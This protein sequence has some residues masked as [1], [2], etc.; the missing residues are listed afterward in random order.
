M[1]AW[2]YESLKT[3]TQEEYSESEEVFLLTVLAERLYAACWDCSTEL[4]AVEVSE[5]RASGSL[6]SE[7]FS[8][9]SVEVET[10]GWSTD[11]FFSSLSGVSVTVVVLTRVLDSSVSADV[12]SEHA[13]DSSEMCASDWC[14]SCAAAGDASGM[15]ILSLT[16]CVAE[17]EAGLNKSKSSFKSW[18]EE[19]L[20]LK[21]NRLDCRLQNFHSQKLIHQVIS[22]TFTLENFVLTR[23]VATS[24]Q[25]WRFL[26]SVT[27]AAKPRP[28]TCVIFNI[29]L[30]TRIL[31][32]KKKKKKRNWQC[33][34][35]WSCW[36]FAQKLGQMV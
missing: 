13:L 29:H 34:T 23:I 24:F 4:E 33:F 19:L 25:A 16:A 35:A 6:R 27:E 31:E 9:V 15:C 2:E 7:V 3:L 26:S 36:W 17:S 21:T 18:L 22:F 5:E 8:T 20:S 32:G 11:E 12:F 30:N 14:V 1:K 10:E 28:S